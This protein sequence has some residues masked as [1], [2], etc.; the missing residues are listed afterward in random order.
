MP[1]RGVLL[2]RAARERRARQGRAATYCRSAA[3]AFAVVPALALSRPT[4]TFL[5]VVDFELE[6]IGL[7]AVQKYLDRTQP[8]EELKQNIPQTPPHLSGPN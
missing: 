4:P 7:K 2:V 6:R 5:V 1:A 8:G 3:A